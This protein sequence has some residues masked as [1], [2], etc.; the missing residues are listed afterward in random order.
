MGTEGRGYLLR[1]PGA[2]EAGRCGNPPGHP[3]GD[4]EA[5]CRAMLGPV[6]AEPRI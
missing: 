2:G 5:S 1:G 6:C 3:G 4:R